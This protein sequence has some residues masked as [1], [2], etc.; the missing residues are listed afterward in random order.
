MIPPFD[1]FRIETDGHLMWR[2]KAETLDVARL[3]VKMLMDE[4]PG[5]YLIYSQ[6]TGHKMIIKADGSI[7]GSTEKDG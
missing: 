2:G 3:K 6:Q 5:N 7:V 4:V 1:I